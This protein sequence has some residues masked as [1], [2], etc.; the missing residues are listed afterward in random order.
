MTIE[1]I[2]KRYHTTSQVMK[3]VETHIPSH[4]F[5]DL[6]TL[7]L[8]PARINPKTDVVEYSGAAIRRMVDTFRLLKNFQ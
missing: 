3:I 5:V 6:S 8:M 4:M 2:S 7:S 1:S